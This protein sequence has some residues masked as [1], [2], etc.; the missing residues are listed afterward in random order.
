[1]TDTPAA[2]SCRFMNM[3]KY[4]MGIPSALIR[5]GVLLPLRV[6][7]LTASTVAFFTALPI[8]VTLKNSSL[9]VI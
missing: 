2:T 1:M 7:S 9:V 5:Y 4:I 6:V 3:F 8:A